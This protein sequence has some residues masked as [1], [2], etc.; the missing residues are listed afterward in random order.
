MDRSGVDGD[1]VRACIEQR[2][3]VTFALHAAPHRERREDLVRRCPHHV[4]Q[5]AASF[6]R[7]CDV[8]ECDLV[9]A[10]RVVAL[11]HLDRVA[12]I[13]QRDELHAFD[14]A[15]VFDIEAGNDA[16]CEHS[17]RISLLSRVGQVLRRNALS[18]SSARLSIASIETGET[19]PN[20]AQAGSMRGVHCPE[21]GTKA[22]P[23]AAKC[24][25]CGQP[26]PDE[27]VGRSSVLA[28]RT[29]VGVSS[30]GAG[31]P[32]VPEPHPD[33]MPTLIKQPKSAPPPEPRP[34]MP[35]QAKDTIMGGVLPAELT[36]H[37][38]PSP[39]ARPPTRGVDGTILGAGPT[40]RPG[41][42][43]RP[44][45]MPHELGATLVPQ[46]VARPRKA[47]RI[48]AE[49][50][51]PDAL[52]VHRDKLARKRVVLPPVRSREEQVRHDAQKR[53]RK[54]I[55]Y[56]AGGLGL[57][58]VASV[59]VVVMRSPA[60]LSA[61]VRITPDGH[62]AIDI[63]CASCPDGTKVAVG[64][65]VA[66]VTSHVAQIPLVAP[67]ALG[68]NQLKVTV[69]RPATGRD[70]TVG[71]PVQ[72][73]FRLRPD[74]SMVTADKPT[75]HVA[76][77]AVKGTEITLDGQAVKLEDG[78]RAH[79]IDVSA[80]CTGSSDEPTTLRRQ[81]A[82][83]VKLP[84]GTRDEG[85]VDFAVG[86]VPLRI[87]APGPRVVTESDTFV[88]A[89]HTMKGAEVLVAGR[90]IQVNPDGAF[91]QRMSV[92]SIGATNIE[93]RAKMLNMAPRIVPIAVQRVEHLEDAAK[94]FQKEKPVGYTT[95]ALASPVD[96]GRPVIVAGQ[97]SEVKAQNHQ[98]IYVIDVPTK[99]GCPTSNQTCRVR[100]VQG[101]APAAKVGDSISAYGLIGRPSPTPAGAAM[102]EILVAFMLPGP[103]RGF[104]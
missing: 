22:K 87:D 2:F 35:S 56:V 51:D 26:L 69:D 18:T 11:G 72:V 52:L 23:G 28:G 20:L 76:V 94:D 49:R 88:L 99:E 33:D 70:E 54:A 7:G 24:A 13:A 31:A 29:M 25:A 30:P 67:L 73:R 86:I 6:V 100:L 77:E 38:A 50:L 14:D 40:G 45:E 43:Q 75:L 82:Y 57:L 78:P 60:T 81:V 47:N 59:V 10:G 32:P 16:L 58:A 5:R 3:D 102:P 97:V 91:A 61:R 17:A 15:S 12:S 44:R 27:V 39:D 104:L 63:D 1:F 96:A 41:A 8:E 103:S 71:I 42:A 9:R 90:P 34:R 66:V 36:K 21:C 68:E 62:Q 55:P 85:T 93:V 101:A 48:G 53:R 92:S 80:D 95:V 4:E 83:S 19:L 84:G 37:S 89:G 65:S 64:D 98:T 74:L 79:A 46:P